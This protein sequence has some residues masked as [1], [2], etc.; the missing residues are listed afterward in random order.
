MNKF[1]F[2][3]CSVVCCLCFSESYSK[4]WSA[5]DLAEQLLHGSRE[6]K[7]QEAYQMLENRD[8]WFSRNS[9]SIAPLY[10]LANLDYSASIVTVRGIHFLAMEAP[11]DKNTGT[12]FKILCDYKVTD[13]VRLTPRFYQKREDCFPYWEGCMNISGRAIIKAG[14]SE[15]NYVFTDNWQH[16]QGIEPKKL[17]DLIKDVKNSK[18]SDSKMI[19]VHCRNGGSRTGT[20]ISA[21]IL[22][23]D[24]DQQIAQGVDINR[25][26]ISID[27]TI[28]EL[29]LQRTFTITHFPQYLTLHQLVNYYIAE[30]SRRI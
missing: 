13:L 19:A 9:F 20:F 25:L 23:D 6:K 21:Y 22:I 17:L 18:S 27:K 16:H 15:I 7:H 28:W 24:I 8:S 2:A 1:I 10:T 26:K 29:S 11:G 4:G 30:L 12:F 5:Q 14:E 3:L